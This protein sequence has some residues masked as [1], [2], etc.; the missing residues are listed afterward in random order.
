MVIG[1]F[2]RLDSTKDFVAKLYCYIIV[3][4]QNSSICPVKL[5]ISIF[6]TKVLKVR[7]SKYVEMLANII[8][9]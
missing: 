3:T 5:F 9:L 1:Q 7:T 8:S 2:P 6:H 4:S